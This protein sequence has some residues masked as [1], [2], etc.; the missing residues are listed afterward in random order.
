MRS[1]QLNNSRLCINLLSCGD[2]CGDGAAEIDNLPAKRTLRGVAL[3]RRNYMFM[4]SDSGADRA[5]SIYSFV[6]TSRL[7]G[8]DPD[9]YLQHVF[10]RIADYLINRIDEL[11]PWGCKSALLPSVVQSR[12]ANSIHVGVPYSV[13]H[14]IDLLIKCESPR[15]VANFRTCMREFRTPKRFSIADLSRSFVHPR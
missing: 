15:S 6:G 1:G 2:Y 3:G 8:L 11:L 7:K 9:A 13:V 10:E 14:F 5:A 4:G 12:C